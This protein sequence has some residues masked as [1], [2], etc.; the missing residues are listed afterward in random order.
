[1]AK[2]GKE[3][4]CLGN[5]NH[6]QK[7]VK[8][9]GCSGASEWPPINENVIYVGAVDAAGETSCHPSILISLP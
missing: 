9:W 6:Y 5:S 2:E 1:M 8:V 4:L 7:E 3:I